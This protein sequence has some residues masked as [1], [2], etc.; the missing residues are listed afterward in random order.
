MLIENL[1]VLEGAIHRIDKAV[2]VDVDA[3]GPGKAAQG[4]ALIAILLEVLATRVELLD[5]EIK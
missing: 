3:L 1:R 5:A 4:I 2:M